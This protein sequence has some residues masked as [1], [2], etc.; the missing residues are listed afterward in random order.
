MKKLI[1]VFSAVLLI[2]ALAIP[3]MATEA[4]FSGEL[5]YGAATPFD[6][7][8]AAEAFGLYYFDLTLT[9]DDLNSVLFEFSGPLGAGTATQNGA[10]RLSYA[11]ITSDVGKALDLPVGLKT[12][13]GITSI[14]SRKY[15]VSGHA[16]ER[17]LVR[18]SIDPAGLVASLDFGAATLDVGMGF[19]Q[20][21][22][23]NDIGALLT[24]PEAG[25]ASIEAFYL[26]NNNDDF[27]GRVGG[28][29]KV[30]KLAD[31]LNLAAGFVFDMAAETWAFGVGAGTT[32][33]MATIGVS[34]NGNDVDILN[35]IGIDVD[36]AL[37]DMFGATGAVGLSMAEGAEAFQGASI[38]GYV[39][40][41][42]SKWRVG[43]LVTSNSYAYGS[44]AAPMEGGL[45]FDAYVAF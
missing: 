15:E 37:T 30:M 11:Q 20:G 6:A 23:K 28:D 31:M 14:W 17:T 7:A 41:G 22:G 24:V 42:A 38:S 32:V 40:V 33:S 35:Q 26:A 19:G 10:A 1:G 8:K 27:K 12:K 9:V 13:A 16:Y 44:S 3:A 21:V 18:S 2:F 34:L 39:K 25:P 36:L 45:F 5:E 43:Y 29:V 4:K